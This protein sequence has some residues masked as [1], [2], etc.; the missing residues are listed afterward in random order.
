MKKGSYAVVSLCC[1]DAF[2]HKSMFAYPGK[3][4]NANKN[5]QGLDRQYVNERAPHVHAFSAPGDWV[6]ANQQ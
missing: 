4:K 6:G 2:G 3:H 1:L 5:I